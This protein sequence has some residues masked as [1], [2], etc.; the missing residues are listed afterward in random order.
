MIRRTLVRVKGPVD[1]RLAAETAVRRTVA[2]S[3]AL[4]LV[5]A[6]AIVVQAWA[7]AGVLAAATGANN[8]DPLRGVLAI[9]A[10]TLVR[11]LCAAAAE[12]VGARG[13][14]SAKAMLRSKLVAAA[15]SRAPAARTI[16]GEIATVAG[17]GIEALEPYIARCLPDLVMA[18]AV[19][20][21]LT[22]VVGVLD[23]LSALIIAAVLVLFPIFGFLVGAG[24]NAMARRRWE[25]VES[26]GRQIA[27]VFE[28]LPMLKA[29]GLSAQQRERVARAGDALSA[30]GLATLRIAFLSALVLDTLASV[31]IALVALPLGLRLLN[32]SV[33]LA[34]ALAVLIV[35]PEV[36]LPLRRASAE[37]HESSEGLAAAQ[38]ALTLIEAGASGGHSLRR[39]LP[40]PAHTRVTL[41][42]VRVEHAG[43]PHP[44]LDDASLTLN[45]GERIV[46]IGANGAGKTTMIDLLLGFL[47]PTRGVVSVGGVG[48]RDAD[49]ESWR[50]HI[51]YLPDRPTLLS[52]SL[53]DNVLLSNPRAHRD[54]V[55][56]ALDAVNAAQLVASLPHG[57]DTIVGDGGRALSMGERQRIAV[58]RVLL[59]D[60][61]LVLLDEPTAHLDAISEEAVIAALDERLR[62][63]T[64]VIVT[65]SAEVRR[66]GDRV[67]LLENGRLAP[68]D[69]APS[70]RR[71]RN[72]ACAIDLAVPA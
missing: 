60:A 63:R 27:D 22:V 2:A 9:A 47:Q 6:A 28:G 8:A 53:R 14:E 21:A 64:A 20:L 26:F 15:V 48:L 4:G 37:F 57:L 5:S 25:Q 23:W 35:A 29:L 34:A 50:R 30:A 18:A 69:V 58:A 49:L 32:G 3:A 54:E 36:F 70:S 33:S 55:M 59:R 62:G 41:D 7:L 43:R 44:V 71:M 12:V 38:S 46:I 40:D 39:T 24:S 17:R 42:R 52:A 19:P 66:L 72:E 13:A 1:R 68:D 61:S 10:A 67:L 45:P 31:S 56:R 51:S 65:H 16:P 11:G